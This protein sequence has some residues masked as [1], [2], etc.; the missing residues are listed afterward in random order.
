MGLKGVMSSLSRYS[1][2]P[3]LFT[4]HEKQL[5]SGV[6]IRSNEIIVLQDLL[7]TILGG[8]YHERVL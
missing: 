3:L 4:E 8:P 1:S 6:H 2:M 5:C 7:G